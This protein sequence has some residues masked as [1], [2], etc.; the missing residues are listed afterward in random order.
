MS[1]HPKW[2]SS[3][4]AILRAHQCFQHT[5]TY[6]HTHLYNTKNREK[7]SE[8][9]NKSQAHRNRPRNTGNNRPPHLMP[10]MQ[11]GPQSTTVKPRC[12]HATSS[13]IFSDKSSSSQR[14]I[15]TLGCIR[16]PAALFIC[17]FTLTPTTQTEVSKHRPSTE[18]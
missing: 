7:E 4:S 2:I 9:Q 16:K 14:V 17:N 8:V 1:P 15:I 13:C 18:Y 3:G 5:H 10:A 12:H 11:C 6:M